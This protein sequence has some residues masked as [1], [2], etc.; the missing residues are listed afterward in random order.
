MLLALAIPTEIKARRSGLPFAKAPGLVRPDFTIIDGVE[1][2]EIDGPIGG[3]PVAHKIALAGQDVV[4]VDSMCC[5]LMGNTSRGC[6]MSGLWDVMP[7]A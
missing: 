1:G 6:Q 7:S 4:A 3:T 5:R 2:M